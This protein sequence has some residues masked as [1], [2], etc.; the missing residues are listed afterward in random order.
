[1]VHVSIKCEL[2]ADI[3]YWPAWNY[4][5][6]DCSWHRGIFAMCFLECMVSGY[7]Y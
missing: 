4:M 1:M 6:S 2:Q 7:T 3:T 5:M